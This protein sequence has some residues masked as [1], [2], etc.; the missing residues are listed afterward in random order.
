MKR[1]PMQRQINC[2]SQAAT[3]PFYITA[4]ILINLRY[5]IGMRTA[6]C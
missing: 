4:D 3:D 6:R 5:Q 1:I 2:I